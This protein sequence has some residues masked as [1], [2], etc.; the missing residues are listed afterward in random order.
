MRQN[1][2]EGGALTTL[3]VNRNSPHGS[4]QLSCKSCET[5]YILKMKPTS[6]EGEEGVCLLLGGLSFTAG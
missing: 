5:A 4:M 3:Q 1:Q 6:I 2:R